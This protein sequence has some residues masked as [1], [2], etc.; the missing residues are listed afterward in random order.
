MSIVDRRLIALT[1]AALLSMTPVLSGQE[2]DPDSQLGMRCATVLHGLALASRRAGFENSGFRHTDGPQYQG[3]AD[4][5]YGW[6]AKRVGQPRG[7][8]ELGAM[9]ETLD[10]REAI[11]VS[12]ADDGE[13]PNRRGLFNLLSTIVQTCAAHQ[14]AAGRGG[15]LLKMELPPGWPPAPRGVTGSR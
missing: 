8:L 11:S 5:W 6:V 1:A 7:Q 14:D 10:V 9:S 12:A 3:R 2:L 4:F 13:Q 15:D